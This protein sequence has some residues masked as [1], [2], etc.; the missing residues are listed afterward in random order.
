MI[1]S[2]IQ[3]C[4][5]I[6]QRLSTIK[7]CIYEWLIFKNYEVTEL[8]NAFFRYLTEPKVDAEVKQPLGLKVK[9]KGLMMKNYCF[10][11]LMDSKFPFWLHLH[12]QTK[13]YKIS[14]NHF[15]P[16]VIYIKDLYSFQIVYYLFLLIR[17]VILSY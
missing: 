16:F 4:G 10:L 14:L 6:F 15:K 7:S 9:L 11:N 13:Y 1:S 17:L 2:Q 5:L 12:D 8:V 3:S